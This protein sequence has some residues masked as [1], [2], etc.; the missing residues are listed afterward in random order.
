MGPQK[1]S[2]ASLRT[3]IYGPVRKGFSGNAAMKCE[4]V[5]FLILFRRSAR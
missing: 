3:Q 2:K 4:F 5:Q 1:A